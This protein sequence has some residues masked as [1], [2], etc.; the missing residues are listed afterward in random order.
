[1]ADP[2][3]QTLS[4]MLDEDNTGQ[5]DYEVTENPDGSASITEKKSGESEQSKDFYRNLANDLSPEE[6][7]TISTSLLEL[8]EK[9]REDRKRRDEQVAEGKKRMGLDK[10]TIGGANFTGASRVTHPMYTKASI[11]F[12]A[13]TIKEL[14]PPG[15]PVREYMAGTITADRQDR[16]RRKARWMNYQLTQLMPNFRS[17]F[18]QLLINLIMDGNEYFKLIPPAPGGDIRTLRHEW[19]PVD[20]MILPY[21]ATNYYSAERRTHVQKMT[22]QEFQRRIRQGMYR[23][24]P[25]MGSPEKPEESET[26]QVI[27]KVEGKDESVTDNIDGLRVVYECDCLFEI[28]DPDKPRSHTESLQED[29]EQEE[30]PEK[31]EEEATEIGPLPYIIS[32]D[33]TTKEVLSIYRNW[34]P[35]DAFQERLDW[36]AEFT[37]I[38]FR[39]AYSLGLPHI[40][41][42]LSIAA[43]GALRALLDSSHINNLAGMV[44]IK[45][46]AG[47]GQNIRISPTEVTEIEGTGDQDDIRKLIMPVPFSPPSPVLLTLLGLLGDQAEQV[48]RTTI[49]EAQDTGDVPVGTTLARIEQGMVAFSAIHGRMHN[50]MDRFLK[51][52]HRINATWLDDKVVVD[53]LGEQLVTQEDFQGP[54]DVLPVSDPNIFCEVQRYGQ[55]QTVAQ[56]ALQLASLPLPPIYDMRKVEELILKQMKLPNDGKD[57]L[58][59]KPEPQQLNPVNENVAICLGRPVVAFPQQDHDAHINTH[60]D[61]YQNPFFQMVMGGSPQ[62]LQAINQHLKEHIIFWYATKVHQIASQEATKAAREKDPQAGKVDIGELPQNTQFDPEI[63]Q[64]YDQMLAKTSSLV[65]QQAAQDPTLQRAAQVMQQIQQA[66]QA[67]QPQFMDPSQ[68]QLAAVR[69]KGEQAQME[70][71]DRQQATQVKQ[72]DSQAKTQS[73]VQIAAQHEAAETQRAQLASATKQADTQANNQTQLAVEQH[74]GQQQMAQQ[75]HEAQQSQAQMAHEANQ[76]Q[77]QLSADAQ[78]QSAQLNHDSQQQANQLSAD[79]QSQQAQMAHDATQQKAQFQQEARQTKAQ[80]QHESNQSKQQQKSALAV[81]RAK[82]GPAKP[83]PTK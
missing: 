7:N 61:Y 38:P 28:R 16:A 58:V 10:E 29:S 40:I 69:Q 36:V 34:N 79:Q 45:G 18:E 21:A 47:T 71:Q 76:Q 51:I 83:K 3:D 12:E 78:Q 8:I 68:A 26:Q 15:G 73:Q 20:D 24:I 49:D 37:F 53:L 75:A 41:G 17:E 44:K 19:I 31:S 56:R 39:G 60:C 32:I 59:Q 70:H 42:G 64:L 62:S 77:T 63:G 6:R 50:A 13:R 9:D 54:S 35:N 57:L 82:G 48:I 25:N 74:K 22:A 80:Q 5:S 72:Q 2:N 1:M 4:G 81:A 52:L 33:V 23:E 43:T 11:D 67:M 65:M 66:L 14:F 27:S 55:I 30:E 46:A